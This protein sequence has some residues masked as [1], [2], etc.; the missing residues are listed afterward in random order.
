MDI[1]TY[2]LA[3]KYTDSVLAGEGPIQGK[4]AYE[5]ALKNGF[6][7]TEAEWLESLKGIKGD[8]GDPGKDGQDGKDGKDGV[9]PEV[10]AIT[11]TEIKDICQ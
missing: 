9:T 10:D 6:N 7:G 5:I 1:I 8:K 2:I 4:S 3:K 11:E